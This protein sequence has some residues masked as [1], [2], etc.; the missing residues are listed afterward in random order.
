MKFLLLRVLPLLLI[1]L[2][3][4]KVILGILGIGGGRRGIPAQPPS[5]GELKK[6]PVCGAYVPVA[7]SLSRVV[8][9]Q[10]VYF[11]SEDCRGKFR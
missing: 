1:F 9:G 11:C 3:L 6:D 5:G 4:R 7:T 10:A 8:N 2:F